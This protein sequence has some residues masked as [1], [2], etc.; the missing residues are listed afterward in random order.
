VPEEDTAELI[1]TT[2]VEV[3][4]LVVAECRPLVIKQVVVESPDRGTRVETTAAVAIPLAGVEVR[5]RPVRRLATVGTENNHRSP[6]PQRITLEVAQGWA[7]RL[8]VKVAEEMAPRE[9][10]TL[11]EVDQGSPGTRVVRA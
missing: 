4:L 3:A 7:E 11:A 9:L 1:V 8:V 10:P 2:A 6:V 5:P